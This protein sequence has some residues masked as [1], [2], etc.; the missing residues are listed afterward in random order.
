[1][2]RRLLRGLLVVLLI[3]HAS[4][5]RLLADIRSAFSALAQDAAHLASPTPA[6]I[7]L[8]GFTVAALVHP[9]DDDVQ[10]HNARPLL[11]DI[12]DCGRVFGSKNTLAAAAS[13]AFVS[14]GTVSQRD[15]GLSS[16][17]L[18][19]LVLANSLVAPLKFVTGRERP[20]GSN[21]RSFPSG[22]SANAFAI[23]TTLARS[24]SP[25]TAF[26]LFGLAAIVP[27]SRI[28][29]RRHF[30]SDVVAGA[31]L[32]TVAALAVGADEEQ[33]G[34]SHLVPVLSGETR[35]LLVSLPL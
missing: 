5:P 14:R 15:D 24:R 19:S 12:I 13:F 3:A 28:H 1:M 8:A 17:L 10:G 2:P 16:N 9:A 25:T 32:G 34:A 20:D 33:R 30:V 31:T 23:A 11:G 22:H 6:I 21:S 29:H 18:R 26:T 35:F 27:I 4:A 7:T